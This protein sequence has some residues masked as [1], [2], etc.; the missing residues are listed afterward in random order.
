MQETAASLSTISSA[1]DHWHGLTRKSLF[2]QNQRQLDAGSQQCEKRLVLY[3][4]AA[5]SKPIQPRFPRASRFC[6]VAPDAAVRMRSYA[7]QG[8][9]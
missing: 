5:V 1:S 4:G 9:R 2:S 3:G 6:A 7:F 8:G